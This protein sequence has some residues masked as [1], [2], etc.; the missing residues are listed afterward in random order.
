[1]RII[2]TRISAHPQQAQH[3]AGRLQAVGGVE[4]RLLHRG[5]GRELGLLLVVVHQMDERLDE[6]VVDLPESMEGEA[7]QVQPSRPLGHALQLV[8]GVEL[9]Q[10][11]IVF[12]ALVGEAGLDQE[13][14]GEVMQRLEEL[15]PLHLALEFLVAEVPGL[16]LQRADAVCLFIGLE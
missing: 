3:F 1:M 16:V 13:G 10:R 11:R 6:V 2:F 7:Q 4:Q 14:P 8:D 12:A 9:H 5:F 15:T